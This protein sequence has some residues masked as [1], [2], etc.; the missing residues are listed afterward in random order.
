MVVIKKTDIITSVAED[1]K[2]Q[3][4]QKLPVGMYN[5]ASTVEHSF[6]KS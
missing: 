2:N 1:V 5:G 4:Q 3:N 6:S